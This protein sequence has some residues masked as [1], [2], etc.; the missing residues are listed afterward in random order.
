[1]SSSAQHNSCC[2]AWIDRRSGFGCHCLATARIFDDRD[3]SCMLHFSQAHPLPRSRGQ[4]GSA[5][6]RNRSLPLRWWRETSLRSKLPSSSLR[7]MRMMRITPTTSLSTGSMAASARWLGSARRNYS[8]P[9]ARRVLSTMAE[10]L[11]LPLQRVTGLSLSQGTAL[12]L[13]AQP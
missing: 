2:K 4:L 13:I 10:Y 6:W 1:M 12:S 5:S 9:R 7:T 11:R 3:P 8:I